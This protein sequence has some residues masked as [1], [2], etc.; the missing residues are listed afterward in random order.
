MK[1]WTSWFNL[2]HKLL[3]TFADH[4]HAWRLGINPLTAI[5]ANMRHENCWWCHFPGHFPT[6]IGSATAERVGRG[7]LGGVTR[8]VKMAPAKPCAASEAHPLGA[9]RAT[10]RVFSISECRKLSFLLAAPPNC[11]F[12]A[13]FSARA[14]WPCPS[15]NSLESGRGQTR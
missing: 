5:G 11:M 15:E 9:E 3:N 7:E 14:H 1:T 8:R 6:K 12:H 2:V 10:C 13:A 4:H